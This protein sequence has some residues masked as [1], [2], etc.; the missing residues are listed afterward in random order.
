M[1][2]LLFVCITLIYLFLIGS[3]A[4]GFDKVK[5]FN[6]TDVSEKTRFSIIIPFRNEAENLPYLLHSLKGLQYPKHLFEVILV[7]DESTD[8]SIEIVNAFIPQTELN[9]TITKNNRETNSPKKD[10][11]TSAIHLAKNE[12]IVSTDADC[13]LPKFW[14]NTFDEYIQINNPSFIVAPVTYEAIDSLLKRFQLL[15]FLSL[16]GATIGGFGMQKP[17]L[18]NG[19]NLSYKKTLFESVN[20]FKGNTNIASGDDIFML[21]KALNQD[22]RSVHY[23][24][25]PKA[26]V[27][28]KA[29]NT[30][31]GLISQRVRWA[32]KTAVT[33]NKFTQSIG[34]T[35]LL[36]NASLI[37]SLVLCITDV[38]SFKIFLYLLIIKLSTDFLLLFKTARFFK[39]ATHLSPYI[40]CGLLYPFFCV[41]IVFVSA[42]TGYNWKGRAFIK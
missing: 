33:K 25:S 34:F 37:C 24:K 5:D 42:F 35:I 6:L 21:E 12:W 39:Q 14:L 16:Q 10:A 27:I 8:N 41:Y 32:S 29:E 30:I 22:A 15:D 31:K 9:I 18:C 11:I 7:D 26:I 23:L 28:T 4:L 20:G 1:I 17:F 40:I 13:R 3:L 38:F 19:A 36:M 2:V